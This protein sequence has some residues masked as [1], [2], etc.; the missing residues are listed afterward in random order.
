MAKGEDEAFD[1]AIAPIHAL[2]ETLGADFCIE[3]A[4]ERPNAP[5][6]GPAQTTRNQYE[7]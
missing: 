6:Q 3:R 7:H 5:D 1:L 2:A 4:D